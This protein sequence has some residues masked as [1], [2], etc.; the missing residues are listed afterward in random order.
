VV[1]GLAGGVACERFIETLLFEVKARTCEAW[2]CHRD[3]AV[4][5]AA[6]SFATGDSGGHDR[7]PR[8][9]YGSE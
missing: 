9:L 2:R 3:A 4:C 5:R 8:R 6:G 7:I 1:I